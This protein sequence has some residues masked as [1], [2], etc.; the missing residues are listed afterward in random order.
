MSSKEIGVPHFAL[1]RGLIRPCTE[2][3]SHVSGEV[4]EGEVNQIALLYKV[5]SKAF[6]LINSPPLTDCLDS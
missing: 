2:Y 4:G 6:G 3:D 1:F 5:E